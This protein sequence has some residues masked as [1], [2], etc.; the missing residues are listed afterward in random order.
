MFVCVAD[1]YK[2]QATNKTKNYEFSY[3]RFIKQ[4]KFRY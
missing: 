2:V 3:I 4:Q 1:C